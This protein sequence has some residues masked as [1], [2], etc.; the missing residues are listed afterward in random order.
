M[1]DA[2]FANLATLISGNWTTKN[3]QLNSEKHQNTKRNR[4]K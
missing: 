2:L 4:N 1:L 3:L